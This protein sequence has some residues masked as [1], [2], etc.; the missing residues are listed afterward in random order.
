MNPHTST[1]HAR[2]FNADLR[3]WPEVLAPGSVVLSHIDGPYDLRKADWDCLTD[4]RKNYAGIPGEADRAVR[5]YLDLLELLG[6][7]RGA[8]L[9]AWYAPI[10]HTISEAS[11]A[12]AS[13]YLWNTDA[14]EALLRPVM[15]ALGWTFRRRIVWDKVI[16]PSI[17]G[18][19]GMTSWGDQTEPCGVYTLGAPAFVPTPECVNNVWRFDVSNDLRKER[20][21]DGAIPDR[22]GLWESRAQVHPCQKPLVFADRVI[23]ASSRSGDL[24]VD[25]FGGTCRLAV[26]N[27]RLPLADRRQIVAFELDRRY[28]DAVAPSLSFVAA[29]TGGQPSLFGGE[30]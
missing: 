25:W 27:A 16:S 6:D 1:E 19:H 10:L 28:L 9:V 29:P 24:V 15:A 3:R 21:Y 22:N 7:R 20:L 18:W 4:A 30:Q 8:D 17:L 23:R 12:S 2:L 13:A 11:A 5:A 14:G 26:A